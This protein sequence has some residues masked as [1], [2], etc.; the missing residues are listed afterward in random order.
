[1]DRKKYIRIASIASNSQQ[2]V[3]AYAKLTY[4]PMLESKT[5]KIEL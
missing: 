3:D 4:S 1:M 5:S 2:L